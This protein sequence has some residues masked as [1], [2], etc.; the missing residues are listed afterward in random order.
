MQQQYDQQQRRQQVQQQQQQQVVQ[1]WLQSKHELKQFRPAFPSSPGSF[2]CSPG[3]WQTC[4]GSPSH[5]VSSEWQWQQQLANV[6]ACQQQSPAHQ[7]LS[8]TAIR[9]SMAGGPAMLASPNM[10][11]PLDGGCVDVYKD[12][13]EVRSTNTLVISVCS[14]PTQ[15]T[16][17]PAMTQDVSATQLAHGESWLAGRAVHAATSGNSRQAAKRLSL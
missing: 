10:R 7:G 2:S 12:G 6:A 4:I 17:A 9:V 16:A 1:P 5:H 3:D 15:P 11:M 13:V 14:S 8:S